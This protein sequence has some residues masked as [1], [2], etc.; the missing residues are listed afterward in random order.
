M[1]NKLPDSG[2]ISMLD[3]YNVLNP[4]INPKECDYYF[5]CKIEFTREWEA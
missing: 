1:A 2:P 3:I 5:E 4:P